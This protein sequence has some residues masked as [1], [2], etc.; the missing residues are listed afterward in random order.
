[1]ALIDHKIKP[2]CWY[3]MELVREDPVA[4]RC[5]QAHFKSRLDAVTAMHNFIRDSNKSTFVP[6]RLE[7]WDDIIYTKWFWTLGTGFGEGVYGS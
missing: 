7:V 1:M 6:I 3:M 5:V 4:Y 2:T